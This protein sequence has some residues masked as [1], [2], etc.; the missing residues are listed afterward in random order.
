MGLIWKCPVHGRVCDAGKETPGFGNHKIQL[1]CS[2]T[3]H[4]GTESDA[5][6]KPRGQKTFDLS[7]EGT[8]AT[9]Y[10]EVC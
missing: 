5:D 1:N 6:A 9:E 7:R 8:P 4:L 3:F 2:A 10:F